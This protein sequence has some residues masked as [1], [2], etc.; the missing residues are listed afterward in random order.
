MPSAAVRHRAK[1]RLRDLLPDAGGG[2]ATVAP[3]DDVA[4]KLDLAKAYGATSD[5]AI[6]ARVFEQV[7]TGYYAPNPDSIRRMVLSGTV[8]GS[9]PRARLKAYVCASLLPPIADSELLSTWIAF[10][11][12]VRARPEIAS[13]HDEQYGR[14][15]AGL[16]ALLL[17]A[18]EAGA[19]SSSPSTVG[20]AAR[21]PCSPARW[22]ISAIAGPGLADHRR[23]GERAHR[24]PGGAV[25][26]HRAERRRG[27]LVLAWHRTQAGAR[28]HPPATPLP[29]FRV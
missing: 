19:S 17:A 4:T 12:L 23:V 5:Q 21:N 8:R 2:D 29:P 27:E 16:A 26:R 22:K 11:S 10:W 14:F 25:E 3:T 20:T 9:D 28:R 15:R 18:G 1:P 13:L 7:S 24:V 6:Q